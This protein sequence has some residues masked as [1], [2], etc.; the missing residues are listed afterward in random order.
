MRI[1]KGFEKGEGVGVSTEKRNVYLALQCA[2]KQPIQNLARLVRVANVLKRLG[3][4]L[5]ADIEH[6]L[7]TTAAIYVSLCFARLLRWTPPCGSLGAMARGS[8]KGVS[9]GELKTS[10]GQDVRV[11]VDEAGAVV[12]LV[13]DDNVQVLLG[14]VLRDVRVGEFLGRRH[15]GGVC[16]S[17]FK[18]LSGLC[19]VEGG[20]GE[21]EQRVSCSCRGKAEGGGSRGGVWRKLG[22]A[23]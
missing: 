14:G 16:V 13:V 23:N 8:C 20:E 11:L 12:H 6:H 9:G 19:E 18:E 7:L 1:S 5:A 2:N 15:C 3:A 4:V 22:V 10:T 17:K 21:S